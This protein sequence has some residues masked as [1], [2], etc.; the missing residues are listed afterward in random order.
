[1]SVFDEADFFQRIYLQQ[2]GNVRLIIKV[3]YDNDNININ[4]I[5]KSYKTINI[6]IN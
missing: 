6:S 1:M 3:L 2:R 4:Q 5:P